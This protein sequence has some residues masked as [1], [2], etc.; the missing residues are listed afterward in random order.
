MERICQIERYFNERLLIPEWIYDTDIFGVYY[1][2]EL[3]QGRNIEAQW[4][5]HYF[6]VIVNA[7]SRDKLLRIDNKE[8]SL[9]FI[10]N[11][12]ITLFKKQYHIKIIRLLKSALP[13]DVERFR[14]KVEYADDGETVKL[15][16]VAGSTNDFVDK[17]A[18]EDM[19]IGNIY[20]LE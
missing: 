4:E 14:K 9:S 20:S 1:L 13:K 8:L 7:S 5:E 3:I 16:Y 19:E 17:I 18:P 15:V 12:T 6:N 10:G 11:V 2:S